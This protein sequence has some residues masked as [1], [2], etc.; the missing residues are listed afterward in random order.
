V[1]H[2]FS[3]G[4]GIDDFDEVDS[5]LGAD[6]FSDISNLNLHCTRIRYI[7]DQRTPRQ[8]GP[9]SFS[10]QAGGVCT[11]LYAKPELSHFRQ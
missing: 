8:G 5:V 3:S 1:K 4:L 10:P 6:G 9:P 7:S 11:L 2:G